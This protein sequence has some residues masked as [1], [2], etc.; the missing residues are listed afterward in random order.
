MPASTST[1]VTV[2]LNEEQLAAV[3]H[4]PGSPAAVI[5]GAG[6]GKTRV[7]TER[8]IWLITERDVIPRTIIALTFTNKAAA[9]LK[10]RVYEALGKDP[11]DKDFKG[12][13]VGTIHSFALSAIRKD[14]HEVRGFVTVVR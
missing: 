4:E 6:S 14:P 10:G 3:T 7:L 9:E 13:R 11:E 12:P 1:G 8:V 2:K 5:A